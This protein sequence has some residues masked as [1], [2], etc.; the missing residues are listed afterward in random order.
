MHFSAFVD[1]ATEFSAILP[2][3]RLKLSVYF[4]L[5][6][7]YWKD[8]SS[9]GLLFLLSCWVSSS[10]SYT[11]AR[12]VSTSRLFLPE[13]LEKYSRF[14]S[15]VQ[16][17]PF[18]GDSHDGQIFDGHGHVQD[19]RS[20]SWVV[21]FTRKRLTIVLVGWLALKWV[22]L[23]E[24]ERKDPTRFKSTVKPALNDHRFKRPPAFSDRFFMHGESAIQTA[25]C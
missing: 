8:F 7:Y 17:S 14:V 6:E 11:I 24:I 4:H 13:R 3:W 18:I 19:N 9:P 23:Y 2:L 16:C 22:T 5:G 15:T 10:L 25:L 20:Q 1:L 12:S 21:G